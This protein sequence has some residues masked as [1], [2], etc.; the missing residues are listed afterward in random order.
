MTIFNA[1]VHEWHAY[2]GKLVCFRLGRLNVLSATIPQKQAPR[3]LISRRISTQ[4]DRLDMQSAQIPLGVPHNRKSHQHGCEDRHQTWTI[5]GL[6]GTADVLGRRS[7]DA[8]TNR[9]A[10]NGRHGCRSIRACGSTD[11]SQS[12]GVIIQSKARGG[13]SGDVVGDER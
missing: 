3:F 2:F 6:A 1:A 5:L 9:A 8:T 7:W 12:R 4:T 13:E 10:E 11:G